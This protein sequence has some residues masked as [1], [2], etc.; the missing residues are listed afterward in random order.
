MSLLRFWKDALKKLALA[1]HNVVRRVFFAVW[2]GGAQREVIAFALIL[3]RLLPGINA[4]YPRKIARVEMVY[5][6]GLFV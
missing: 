6:D 4:N 1:E 3:V 5:N 2:S